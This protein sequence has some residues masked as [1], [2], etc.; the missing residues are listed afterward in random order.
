MPGIDTAQCWAQVLRQSLSSS[1]QSPSSAKAGWGDSTTG[2][3]SAG[4]ASWQP[5]VSASFLAMADAW[6][7][8]GI[9]CAG[10]WSIAACTTGTDPLRI[11]ARQ[12]RTRSST[13]SGDMAEG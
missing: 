10:A 13:A 4:A 11:S 3:G 2:A 9:A 1:Q 12:S 5:P 6:S 7:M 8:A